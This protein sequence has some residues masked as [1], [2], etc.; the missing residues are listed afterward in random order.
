MTSKSDVLKFKLDQ[1]NDPDSFNGVAL[2]IF[3]YQRENNETYKDFLKH[4]NR[5]P[6]SGLN[7]KAIGMFQ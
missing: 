4:T 2:E 7:A 5:F 6:M 3:H 1:V